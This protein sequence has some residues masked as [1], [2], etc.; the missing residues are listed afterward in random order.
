MDR[1]YNSPDRVRERRMPIIL[2]SQIFLVAGLIAFGIWF[3]DLADLPFG[4]TKHLKLYLHECSV[5]YDG[6]QCDGVETARAPYHFEIDVASGSIRQITP[7]NQKLRACRI[8]GVLNW[9]CISDTA[10]EKTTV[11]NGLLQG[12]EPT[13]RAVTSHEFKASKMSAGMTTFAAGVYDAFGL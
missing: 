3:L 9:S 6:D 1:P 10:D 7:I 8:E 2:T 13:V 5:A 4:S 12:T 11:K